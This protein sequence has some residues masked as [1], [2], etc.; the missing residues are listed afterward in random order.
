MQVRHWHDQV[1]LLW[2]LPGVFSTSH[3]HTF[4]ALS[5][6]WGSSAFRKDIFQHT[7][8]HTE[9]ILLSCIVLRGD[10]CQNK[11]SSS[12]FPPQRISSLSFVWWPFERRGLRKLRLASCLMSLLILIGYFICLRQAHPAMES[13][14]S[15]NHSL[16]GEEDS[17]SYNHARLIKN[18]FLSTVYSCHMFYRRHALWMQLLR[19]PTLSSPQRLMRSSCTTSKR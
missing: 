11:M 1:H 7:H 9:S 6:V 15:T 17:H 4:H 5:S 3:A 13:F 19:G 2:I 8:T 12:G 18:A 16:I 14:D 10:S